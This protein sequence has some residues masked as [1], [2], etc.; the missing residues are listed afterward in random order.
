MWDRWSLR[1]SGLATGM[2]MSND[3]VQ[4]MHGSAEQ[5]LMSSW[6]KN[7]QVSK[8]YLVGCLSWDHQQ[9]NSIK[10]AAFFNVINEMARKMVKN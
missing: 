9:C 4:V 8:L 10:E 6:R 5:P 1:A 3:N 7:I 2:E